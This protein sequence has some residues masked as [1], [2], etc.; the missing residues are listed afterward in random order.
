[1]INETL[2]TLVHAH[3]Y[4]TAA[5]ALV[6][7][8]RLPLRRQFGA[9]TAYKTW[10][11]V[12]A[13]IAAAFAPIEV[14]PRIIEATGLQFGQA[15]L[16]ALEA[17]PRDWAVPA[18][19]I[20]LAGAA[21]VAARFRVSHRLF[22]RRLGALKPYQGIFQSD[23][24]FAGPALVG[25]LRPKV[26]VP[27]D[28]QTRYTQTEQR[29]I[30]QH[31]EMHARRRD[32]WG[33][34]M[35]AVL[36]CVFWFNPL[37]HLAALL[38]RFD[39]ELACDARVIGAHPTQRRA[40]AAALLKSQDA[41]FSPA[42]DI[43]CR[44]RS[45]HPIKERIMNLQ[46]AQPSKVRRTIGR[47]VIG[48]LTFTSAGMALA[49]RGDSIAMGGAAHYAIDT[50]FKIAGKSFAPRFQAREGETVTVRSDADG[51][52]FSAEFLVRSAGTPNSVQIKASIKSGD[53]ILAQPVL[54]STLGQASGIRIGTEAGQ[55]EVSLVVTEL[56]K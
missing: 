49:F 43:A 13:L 34:L 28:F 31:E 33:N 39:Q 15:L 24:P 10:V 5:L 50:T 37:V 25:L 56:A 46:H 9:E 53:V 44:W 47:I 7:A 41:S 18:L 3:W 40:Y 38:F 1:M 51:A 32:A 21:F 26:V 6:F 14:T 45:H 35:Q 22:V 20:W 54:F 4:L 48:S 2:G 11:L 29:L 55:L 23:E 36:Q 27:L 17:P 52:P 8:V 12:P 19:F 30:I 42:V 16:P